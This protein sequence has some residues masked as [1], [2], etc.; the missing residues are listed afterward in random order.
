ME[1]R[2][3]TLP[4]LHLYGQII[5]RVAHRALYRTH[6]LSNKKKSR[7]PGLPNDILNLIIIVSKTALSEK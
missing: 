5:H 3:H 1:T 6:G 2:P 7:L 4:H